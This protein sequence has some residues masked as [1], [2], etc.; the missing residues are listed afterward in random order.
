M[1]TLERDILALSSG[2]I[3]TLTGRRDYQSID[4]I[5]GD[6]LTFVRYRFRNRHQPWPT[7]AVAW[8]DFNAY[9]LRMT[10]RIKSIRNQPLNSK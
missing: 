8:T 3:A 6:F 4:D 2:T 1:T 5:Q 9:R 7:W 10:A